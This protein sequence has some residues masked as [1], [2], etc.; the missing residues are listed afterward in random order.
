MLVQN[1]NI[2]EKA[3]EIIW[4]KKSVPKILSQRLKICPKRN[5]KNITGPKKT[6]LAQTKSVGLK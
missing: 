3:K 1:Y 5:I 4:L 6:L 2:K